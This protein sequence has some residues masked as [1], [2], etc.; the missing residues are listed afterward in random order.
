MF[1]YTDYGLRVPLNIQQFRKNILLAHR[2]GILL[3]WGRD[4]VSF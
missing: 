1:N 3:K 2:D 4:D